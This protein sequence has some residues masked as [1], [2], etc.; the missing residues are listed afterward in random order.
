MKKIWQ[1]LI[2]PPHALLDST[3]PRKRHKYSSGIAR[4]LDW[5]CVLHPLGLGL[6]SSK[7]EFM[8]ELFE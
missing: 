4:F 1:K 7:E 2:S 8:G 3:V 6:I 5:D